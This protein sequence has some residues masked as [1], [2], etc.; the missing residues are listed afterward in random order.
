MTFEETYVAALRR[1][2]E[3][4]YKTGRIEK[5]D[6]WDAG[7]G[8]ARIELVSRTVSKMVTISFLSVTAPLDEHAGEEVVSA[9]MSLEKVA[10]MSGPEP[11]QKPMV[12]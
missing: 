7:G 5:Y 12:Q 3:L 8:F 11:K 10:Q 1:W 2:L 9:L 4:A 6:A